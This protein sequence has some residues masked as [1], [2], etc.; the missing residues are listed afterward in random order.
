VSRIPGAAPEKEWK[1]DQQEENSHV[2]GTP[3]FLVYTKQ[4]LRKPMASSFS[5]SDLP[6]ADK[7]VQIG[8]I[9]GLLTLREKYGIKQNKTK[10]IRP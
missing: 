2:C 5:S 1:K 6:E 9:V 7:H 3:S 10:K 4:T 8:S